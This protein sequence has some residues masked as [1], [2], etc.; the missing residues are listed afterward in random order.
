LRLILDKLEVSVTLHF[1]GAR[2]LRVRLKAP[3]YAFFFTE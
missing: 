2:F 1:S 3:R